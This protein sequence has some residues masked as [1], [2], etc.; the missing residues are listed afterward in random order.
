MGGL[1]NWKGGVTAKIYKPLA[2]GIYWDEEPPHSP[3]ENLDWSNK[4]LEMAGVI[5][6]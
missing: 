4:Y 2:D 3:Q 6:G 1:S 5:L